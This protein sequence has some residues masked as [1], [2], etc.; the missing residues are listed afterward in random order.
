MSSQERV[1]LYISTEM[2][3]FYVGE[4]EK[5]GISL[6]GYIGFVLG[7]YMEEK[8][9]KKMLRKLENFIEMFG[10]IEN[11][12]DMSNGEIEDTLKSIKTLVN[13]VQEDNI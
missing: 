2:K 4:A 8:Q 13:Y 11:K 3:E 9:D 10:G 5:A 7:Q 12:E 6:S 1:S